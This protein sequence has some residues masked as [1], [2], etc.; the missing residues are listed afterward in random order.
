ME[1]DDDSMTDN[2]GIF[3][4]PQTPIAQSF[5]DKEASGSNGYGHFEVIGVYSVTIGSTDVPSPLLTGGLVTVEETMDKRDLR[6]VFNA[7][8]SI[9]KVI[10][11]GAGTAVA[12][13]V[14]AL[15]LQIMGETQLML[16]GNALS[17][18]EIPA[19]GPNDYTDPT[20]NVIQNTGYDANTG[21]DSLI[22][23]NMGAGGTD[24]IA[25][26]EMA[27]ASTQTAFEYNVEDSNVT[28]P[29]VSF[30]TKYRHREDLV[31]VGGCTP[32][33]SPIA[34]IEHYSAPF[35]DTLIGEATYTLVSFDNYENSIEETDDQFSGG[36]ELP[37]LRLPYEVN[38]LT[39]RYFSTSGWASIG[40]IPRAS[41]SY[42]GMPA[43]NATLKTKGTS[44]LWTENGDRRNGMNP[45]PAAPA[46]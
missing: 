44:F 9:T 32:G 18:Y 40:W 7:T 43:L 35:A 11:A 16:D 19:L 20:T 39:P 22:G 41:C 37:K 6:A 3:G 36:D 4:S 28:V 12:S 25:D 30:V 27:I 34:G 5:F 23:I 8:D 15:T 45:A 31:G 10:G 14:D 21:L 24:N 26:I 46:E 13:S 38:L 17:N 1:S 2:A 42:D 33:S 29:V